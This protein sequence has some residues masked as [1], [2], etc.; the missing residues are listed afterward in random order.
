M[1]DINI[2]TPKEKMAKLKENFDT[3]VEQ[4]L[5]ECARAIGKSDDLTATIHLRSKGFSDPVI[6]KAIEELHKKG[7]KA[8]VQK[9]SKGGAR[10]VISGSA[11]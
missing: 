10:L 1:T 7:W 5:Q 8:E 11:S 2:P 4:L 3:A 9:G 6:A